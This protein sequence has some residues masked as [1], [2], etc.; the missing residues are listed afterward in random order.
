MS[1]EF[2]RED[3]VEL[4]RPR[5]HRMVRDKNNDPNSP[6]Y[7]RECLFSA[8]DDDRNLKWIY[9]RKDS[10]RGRNVR[11]GT[12]SLLHRYAPGEVEDQ[13]NEPDAVLRTSP[14]RRGDFR[15]PSVPDFKHAARNEI[16]GLAKLAH[17]DDTSWSTAHGLEQVIDVLDIDGKYVGLVT[18]Y[19]PGI[20]CV[21]FFRDGIKRRATPEVLLSFGIQLC[22]A[23]EQLHQRGAVHGDVKPGNMRMHLPKADRNIIES[24]LPLDSQDLNID[25]RTHVSLV[26]YETIQPISL[27]G[28]RGVDNKLVKFEKLLMSRFYSAPEKY[29]G[30]VYHSSDLYSVGATLLTLLHSDKKYHQL[31]NENGGL[32]YTA[33]LP[34]DKLHKILQTLLQTNYEHR[35]SCTVL[36]GGGTSRELKFETALQLAQVLK[37]IAISDYGMKEYDYPFHLVP[38]R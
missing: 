33:R 37:G 29:D 22:L 32:S 19:I 5:R 25:H 28:D 4:P 38:K 30:K 21:E 7:G 17:E 26:D 11:M 3:M 31:L 34:D 18:K 8:G 16:I 20:D 36:E 6:L 2:S 23:L 12:V 1:R 35:G 14:F 24:A 13:L 15:I 9:I 27:A 10:S